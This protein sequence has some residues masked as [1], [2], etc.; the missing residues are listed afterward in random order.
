MP[1]YSG[2]VQGELCTPTGAAILK[3]FADGFG[4]MPAMTMEKIGY[5]MGT[6]TFG[7]R[8]NC[9]RV[10]TGEAVEEERAS[11]GVPAGRGE[12]TAHQVIELV[13]NL[14]D[15]TAEEIG[16]AMEILMEKGAL[17]VY[18]QSIVMKKSRPGVKLVCMCRP[19]DRE[20]MASL[21]F[22]H[23]TTIGIR[24]YDCSRMILDRHMEERHTPWGDV[25]VKV[26]SGY[27]TEKTKGEFDQMAQ[28]ARDNDLSLMEI[29]K[30]L[31]D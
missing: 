4:Q 9:V 18:C 7:Q 17:D 21:M 28:M 3:H 5:G 23:T 12:E 14:D 29:K 19:E 22:K 8:A 10:M 11:A 2:D 27:G 25:A 20:A 31:N 30:K 26:C 6:R 13:A 1:A 24:Q 16:Y 15:M